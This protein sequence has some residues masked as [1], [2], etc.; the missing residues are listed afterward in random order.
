MNAVSYNYTKGSSSESYC[1][2]HV[3]ET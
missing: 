1:F 2:C 3:R